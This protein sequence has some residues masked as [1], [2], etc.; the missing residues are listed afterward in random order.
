MVL[1][2]QVTYQVV[3]DRIALLCAMETMRCLTGRNGLVEAK[4]QRPLWQKCRSIAFIDKLL[5]L[6]INRPLFSQRTIFEKWKLRGPEKS[7][8]SIWDT[9]H[10]GFLR[11]TY[12]RVT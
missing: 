3:K 7:C 11:Y 4:E 1:R 6:T 10:G 12:S 8:C 9:L 5:I 2:L